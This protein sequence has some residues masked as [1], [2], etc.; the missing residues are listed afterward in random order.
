MNRSR[1]DRYCPLNSSVK[2][3]G[4]FSLLSV[5]SLCLC[6]LLTSL[7]ATTVRAQQNGAEPSRAAFKD[8]LTFYSEGDTDK[9]I[10]T[11][12]EVIK[13]NPDN[14]DAY[15]EMGYM[16]LK[17]RE[18]GEALSAFRSALKINPRMRT[19]RTGVGLTLYEKGDLAGAEAA[20]T[21]ALALNPY[22]SRAHYA[23][24]LV[25]EARKDY[26]KSIQEYKE[27]LRTYKR[28]KK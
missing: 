20:L 17:K 23:L 26:E 9:A 11:M 18:F 1:T 27:G 21:D 8:A 12:R 7:Y 25:Y 13:N 22:P 14:V 2:A 16:F 15:E 10:K 19:A 5:V 28:G 3:G 4:K 24:G 6:C